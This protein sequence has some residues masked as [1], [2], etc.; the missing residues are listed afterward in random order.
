MTD[1]PQDNCISLSGLGDY[2]WFRWYHRCHFS[3]GTIISVLIPD[4][5]FACPTTIKRRIQPQI[6]VE[7]KSRLQSNFYSSGRLPL[8]DL[9][10]RQTVCWC[11]Q[12]LQKL[13]LSRLAIQSQ[14]TPVST[15]GSHPCSNLSRLSKCL[16]LQLVSNHF[17][18]HN[19]YGSQHC[20]MESCPVF[21]LVP[22]WYRYSMLRSKH[23]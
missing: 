14:T 19:P 10:S 8:M 2:R 16:L 20:K 11:H 6:F 15:S 22:C 12:W 3:W 18:W 17:C 21:P 5:D 13:Y 7:R 4:R 9:L 23:T 1:C